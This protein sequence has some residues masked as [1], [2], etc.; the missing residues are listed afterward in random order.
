MAGIVVNI[1]HTY[2]Y[3][4]RHHHVDS[5]PARFDRRIAAIY[6]H[7]QAVFITADTPILSLCGGATGLMV[8]VALLPSISEPC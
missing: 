2:K 4:C 3:F 8:P 5:P 6:K 1:S 7:N